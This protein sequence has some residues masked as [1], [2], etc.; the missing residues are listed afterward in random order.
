MYKHCFFDENSQIRAHFHE[1]GCN[2]PPEG[3]PKCECDWCKL[4]DY[5]YLKL[6]SKI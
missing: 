1:R 4:K 5:Y 3:H 6:R 2:A